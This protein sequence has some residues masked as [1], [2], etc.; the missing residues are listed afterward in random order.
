[1]AATRALFVPA[2]P[3]A[4]GAA[5]VDGDALVALAP[6]VLRARARPHR[7]LRRQ[8]G[9]PGPHA[10]G[11][12]HPRGG[13]RHPGWLQI[14]RRIGHHRHAGAAARVLLRHQEQRAA[15][16]AHGHLLR[17]GAL[18][19]QALRLHHHRAFGTSRSQLPAGAP[20]WR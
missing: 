2:W 17:A 18:L 3:P 4:D 16:G 13:Q 19:P 7:Q 20:S 15:A 14:S 5:L 6:R 12:R 10:A 11:R 1:M 8:K 9:R